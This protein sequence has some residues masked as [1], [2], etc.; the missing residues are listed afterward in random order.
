MPYIKPDLHFIR[1]KFDRG[2]NVRVVPQDELRTDAEEHAIFTEF[3]NCNWSTSVRNRSAALTIIIGDAKV[4]LLNPNPRQS[5]ILNNLET[6]LEKVREY[7]TKAPF[8]KVQ[9]TMGSNGVFAP[10]CTLYSSIH[11]FMR[12]GLM[13]ADWAVDDGRWTRC[14]RDHQSWTNWARR[15]P[16]AESSG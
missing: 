4:K 9:R 13:P 15:S 8:V 16:G 14:A 11:R 2:A 5:E 7:M 10:R 3:G 12:Q 1:G 6:T